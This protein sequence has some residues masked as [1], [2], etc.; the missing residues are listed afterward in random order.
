MAAPWAVPRARGL[1]ASP[2]ERSSAGH[3]PSFTA[4]TPPLTEFPLLLRDV[5]LAVNPLSH[6]R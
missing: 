5:D 6:P 3:A 2:W 4:S 1:A